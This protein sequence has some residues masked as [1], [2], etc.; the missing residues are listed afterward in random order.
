MNSSKKDV[1]RI[2]KRHVLFSEKP[3]KKEVFIAIFVHVLM[4]ALLVVC[5]FPP[6]PLASLVGMIGGVWFLTIAQGLVIE[7][8]DNSDRYLWLVV[9]QVVRRAK[10]STTNDMLL[11]LLVGSVALLI[12]FGFSIL[13]IVTG[14]FWLLYIGIGGAIA[15]IVAFIGWRI[16][17]IATQVKAQ[18]LQKKTA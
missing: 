14:L 12:L 10:S 17:T 18:G 11:G 7:L 16:W 9:N 2:I 8:T 4:I 13:A 5:A 15:V 3:T 6:F 1:G